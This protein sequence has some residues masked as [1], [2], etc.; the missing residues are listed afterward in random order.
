MEQ[1][2]S[3]QPFEANNGKYCV[4]YK[5]GY[6]AI[7]SNKKA[8]EALGMIHFGYSIEH[9]RR[10]TGFEGHVRKEDVIKHYEPKDN[11]A[12]TFKVTGKVECTYET[13]MLGDIVSPARYKG[14]NFKDHVKSLLQE[15]GYGSIKV[16]NV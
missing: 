15:H 9:F 11:N 1:T 10:R 7:Y 14:I 5:D 4:P 8:Y 12:Y 2:S 13:T 16:T 6:F 3:L